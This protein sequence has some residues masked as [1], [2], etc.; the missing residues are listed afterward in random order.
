MLKLLNEIWLLWS[1]KIVNYVLNTIPT[2]KL[3]NEIKQKIVAM[4]NFQLV[5]PKCDC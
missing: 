1:E 5:N 3:F 2:F 4:T